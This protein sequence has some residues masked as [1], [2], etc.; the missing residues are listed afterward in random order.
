[1]K[2]QRLRS[3]LVIALLAL[4]AGCASAA[5]AGPA[6]RPVSGSLTGYYSA[7]PDQPNLGMAVG[8][9]NVGALRFEGRYNYEARA[10]ASAFVGWKF[11]GG[12]AIA[13]EVTPL[14]GTLFGRTRGVV[15][16]FGAA[17]SWKSFDFYIEAEYVFDRDDSDASYAYAWSELGWTPV[18]WLRVGLVGQRTRV[19]SWTTTGPSS[20]ACCCSCSPARRL[21]ASTHSTRTI[22]IGTRRSRS[23]SRS[24][25]TKHHGRPAFGGRARCPGTRRSSHPS[26]LVRNV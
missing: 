12:D 22:P 3:A 13:W 26:A 6:D 24:R 4:A 19:R 23:A 18:E 7:L 9:V 8:S 11:E 15:P 17:L 16:G 25:H 2:G 5:D 10:S 1:M 20:A 21:S 14:I